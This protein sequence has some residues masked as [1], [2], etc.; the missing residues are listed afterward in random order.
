MDLAQ[1]RTPRGTTESP[2]RGPRPGPS[3]VPERPAAT[4]VHRGIAF[5][6]HRPRT[7]N[8]IIST[9]AKV[10]GAAVAF[11]W[12]SRRSRKWLMTLTEKN[13]QPRHFASSRKSATLRSPPHPYV[14]FRKRCTTNNIAPRSFPGA[15]PAHYR[16]PP[17]VLR[18]PLS[19]LFPTTE[20]QDKAALQTGLHDP[21]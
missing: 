10:P 19:R 15:R 8:G 3:L 17:R 16:R 21:Q 5:S 9:A 14:I 18:K 6:R 20:G 13:H 2:P 1:H 7:K 4:A 11:L 12:P